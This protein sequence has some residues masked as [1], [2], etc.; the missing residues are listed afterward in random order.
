[1]LPLSDSFPTQ[2]LPWMTWLIIALNI[3]VF[4]LQTAYGPDESGAR[5][6]AYTFG[7]L[8]GVTFGHHDAELAQINLGWLAIFTSMFMHGGLAHLGGNMLYLHIF[9]DNVEDRL[10]KPRF[11]IFY[12]LG[13][14][15]AALTQAL[16]DPTSLIPMIGASGAISALLGAYIVLYPQQRITVY[17]P[18]QGLV[19]VPAIIVLGVWFIGQFLASTATSGEQGGVAVWAHIG[20]FIFGAA[21]IRLFALGTPQKP[22][23][24]R[25]WQ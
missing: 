22:P 13:G 4:I 14:V 6:L 11:V 12:L 8:P 24:P 1:M 17:A 2:R 10:G 19:E 20:G 7:F 25:L 5:A 21:L 9:G 3:I 18:Y 23:R 16:T 15:A